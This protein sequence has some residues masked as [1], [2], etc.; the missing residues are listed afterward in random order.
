MNN[1]KKVEEIY[2]LLSTHFPY[3]ENDDILL[4]DVLLDM[5]RANRDLEDRICDLEMEIERK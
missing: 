5:A 4:L 3:E 2:E 1:H